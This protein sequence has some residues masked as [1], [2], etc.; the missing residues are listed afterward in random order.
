[1][2][3][4]IDLTFHFNVTGT[5][6]IDWLLNCFF[7]AYKHTFATSQTLISNKTIF[8]RLWSCYWYSN[9]FYYYHTYLCQKL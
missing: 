4:Q 2:F 8:N 5:V 3:M 1:M 7:T 6:K 9:A